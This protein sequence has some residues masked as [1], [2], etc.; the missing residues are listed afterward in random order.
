[1]SCYEDTEEIPGLKLFNKNLWH[2]GK[3]KW[4]RQ[5][6]VYL[7]SFEEAPFCKLD[8][9]TMFIVIFLKCV[10]TF[11][12]PFLES[13]RWAWFHH[14]LKYSAWRP[15]SSTNDPG[16]CLFMLRAGKADDA[17]N[18][19]HCECGF[20]RIHEESSFISGTGFLWHWFG[21]TVILMVVLVVLSFICM[22][23]GSQE[24]SG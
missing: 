20:K 8:F 21:C 19:I 10:N 15:V 23:L 2:M 14:T 24:C 16:L 12:P 22:C 5:G 6:L 9:K 3:K 4:A 13:R 18:H 7:L 17:A 11:L 1:M